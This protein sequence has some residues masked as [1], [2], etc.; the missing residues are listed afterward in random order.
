[1]VADLFGPGV[2]ECKGYIHRHHVDPSDP[3]SRT[4]EVCNAHHQR[5]H[6]ALRAL[7]GSQK[8]W[9]RC[10]HSHP[11]PGGREACERRLN[12]LPAVA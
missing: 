11:Y 3:D 8:A 7:E 12:G 1:M 6:A 10:T 9:K 2:G 5:L 4:I